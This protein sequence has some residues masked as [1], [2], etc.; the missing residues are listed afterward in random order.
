MNFGIGDC[1][2]LCELTV[3]KKDICELTVPNIL[4]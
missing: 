2:I 3:F 1:D 4:N